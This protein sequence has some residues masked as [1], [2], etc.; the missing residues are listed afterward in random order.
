MILKHKYKLGPT[1]KFLVTYLQLKRQDEIK[2]KI[3]VF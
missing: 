3:L 2:M 1:V